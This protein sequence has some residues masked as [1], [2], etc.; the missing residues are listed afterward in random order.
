MASRNGR[1]R[2]VV[3]V[4]AAVWL[5]AIVAITAIAMEVSRLTDTATEVQVAADASAL[6]AA[7]NM[8]AGGTTASAI[9][10]GATVAGENRT[11]GRAPA[12]GQV[13]FEFGSYAPATGFSP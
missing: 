11:D 5:A 6:A 2:G 1:E 3:M 4:V 12:P 13:S 9:V 8:I 10:A 7:Q